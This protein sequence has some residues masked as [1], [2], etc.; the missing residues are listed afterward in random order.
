[1]NKY[2]LI[3]M[4][5]V[6][7]IILDYNNFYLG[8]D[9]IE[10]IKNCD[11]PTLLSFKDYAILSEVSKEFNNFMKYQKF[12][13]FDIT[14]IDNTLY[15]Y[16]I[17]LN[18]S[19]LHMNRSYYRVTERFLQIFGYI[20]L[21]S[22]SQI[23]L[24][25]DNPDIHFSAKSVTPLHNACY[26]NKHFIKL[27]MKYGA[28]MDIDKLDLNGMTPIE[29]T[30][31]V[32]KDNEQVCRYMA[33]FAD[34]LSVEK[35]SAL[36]HAACKYSWTKIIVRLISFGVNVNH[37]DKKGRPPVF[38]V[39]S[40]HIFTILKDNGADLSL[41][42]NKGKSLLDYLNDQEFSFDTPDIV[43]IKQFIN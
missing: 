31:Y 16:L 33:K 41:L 39:T 35:R 24:Y 3:L 38:M 21:E 9:K 32:G 42:D 17:K 11:R 43:K 37:K 36:L 4:L 20:S 2:W 13:C 28:I 8:M 6:L 5:N 15:E 7:K 34:R 1:M 30:F 12:L 27:L 18:T 10:F 26:Y 22:D 25:Y 14:S 19:F 40:F 29:R 23:L